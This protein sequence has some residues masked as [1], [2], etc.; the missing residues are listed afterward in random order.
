MVLGKVEK[1]VMMLRMTCN[2]KVRDL[3]QAIVR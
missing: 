1:K 3:S 2:K